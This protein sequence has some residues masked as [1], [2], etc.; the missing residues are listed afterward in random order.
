MSSVTLLDNTRRL[1][2]ILHK[3]NSGKVAFSDICDEMSNILCANVCVLSKK[4]KIL[5]KG[6]FKEIKVL[7]SFE[8]LSVG[9]LVDDRFNRRM[10]DIL[11]TKENVYLQTL[12]FS[13]EESQMYQA[14]LTPIDIAGERCGNLFIYKYSP[15]YNL[16]N[17]QNNAD[18]R[19]KK[20][21][22][23]DDIIICEY[24]ATVVGLEMLR[25]LSE[26]SQEEER[27]VHGIQNALSTLTSSELEAVERIFKELSGCEGVLVASKIADKAGITRSV[28]V[29]ALRKLESAEIISSRSAGM[30]GTYIKVLNELIYDMLEK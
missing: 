21:F 26:E 23:I 16:E 14:I 9:D 5:G 29:N 18:I 24:G 30:K 12:G 20:P 1:N 8:N 10:G 7:D 27:K 17:N 2:A 13:E 25:A 28:I 3:K 22:S 11:S 4:G 19:V 15:F 6:I